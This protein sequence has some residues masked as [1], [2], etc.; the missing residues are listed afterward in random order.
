MRRF[1]IG[2]FVFV[3]LAAV[4][5]A[6]YAQ[7]SIVG[8]VRDISGAVMPGVTV[9]A[10]S[11][12]LIEKTRSVVTSGTGQ[13]AIVDL[14]PGT[15]TVTFTLPGFNTVRRE[16]IELTGNFVASVSVDMRVGAVEET[17]TV[18]GEAPIVDVTNSRRQQTISGDVIA[19]IPSS[20][21]Y[22]GLTTLV[23]ALNIQG[24]DIGGASGPIF[25][26][27]QIH[28][29]RRNE[30][31]VLV[32][33][34]S[35]GFQGMGVSFYVPEVGTAQEV[36][37]SLSGGLGEAPTGGPQ[38]NIVP[39][40]GGNVF[41]GSLFVTGANGAMQGD[42]IT[43]EIRDAGLT[44]RNELKK[45]WEVNPA[46][47]GPIRRDRL[48]F[49]GTFRHQGNRQL[50]AGMFENRN[51]GDP[52]KWTYD[53]DPSRQAIDDGTWKNGSL[54]LTWQATPRNKFNVWW[55]EQTVCQ[56]CIAGGS[57]TGLVFAGGIQ[58]P[59]A[60]GRTEGFPA[61]MAQATW[62]SP[63]SNRLL[64]EASLGLGPDL[65]FGGLQKNSYDKTLI[66]VT[67]QGGS[68]PNLAYRAAFWS[69][70]RGLTRV[71][72]GSL[73]YVTG[74]HNAKFGG[75][76]HYNDSL[77]VNFY[78]DSQLSYT[79]LNGSPTQLTMFGNHDV[80]QLVT[81]GMASL[82]A[83]DQWTR[84][85]LTLQGGVR[86][87]HLSA[88]FPDQQIGPNLYIPTAIRFPARDS[89]V[90]VKD[91]MPRVGAAYD[92]FG[93]G[94]TAVKVF[95]GRYV[96]P[97]NSGEAYAGGQ[98]PINRVVTMTNRAWTDN[99]NFRPDCNLLNPALQDNRASGGDLCGPWS[100][101]NFGKEVFATT[102][103]PD[104]LTG[105]N[106]REYSWD[107]TTTVS[108]QLA[109]RVSVELSYARR[110]WGNFQVTDN[111]AVGPA[112]F[113]PFTIVAPQDQRLPNGGGYSLQF[114]DIKPAKF[115]QFDNFI[116]FSDNYGK[117]IYH[118][119]GIDVN[120]NAR[121]PF[122][123]TLQGGFSTGNMT[124]DDCEVGESVP[125]IYIPPGGGGTLPAVQSTAQWSRT[126]CH[127][128]SG[129]L[130]HV[131]GLATYTVPKVDV[132]ISGTFQSKP[133]VGANFPNV[134]SQSIPANSVTPNAVIAP[135]LGRPLAGGVPVTVLGLVKPGDKY[136]DRLNQVDLRFGK[137][138]RFGG[139]RTLVALDLFNAFNTNTTDVYQTVYG[140]T[141]LNPAS[142]MA[143]RLAKIS[144]QFD[145]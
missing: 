119:N 17:V 133:Y 73:S 20:R 79:F 143:A 131:K 105:W 56:H 7:A 19:A 21:Q 42:N 5:I 47:G 48:W 55:D 100:N 52:T 29:G 13:Y 101:Q 117:Q 99:G 14:R 60:H 1:L 115:G 107:L 59:E 93:N 89:G 35:M 67:D 129:Y 118:F 15:Y 140:P 78:N 80:R 2:N 86:F 77:G 4:P 85:R 104:L 72:Q 95:I 57:R 138:L 97:T 43:Q 54:R 116:T 66:R 26:V 90:G 27:F 96:T 11:P 68:I 37:F 61:R 23:P 114:Y 130:T 128:E 36:T 50:V 113:D 103:D 137:L 81:Q 121:F 41:S 120:V 109:P 127:R 25:S 32:D 122:A 16:G 110:V 70:P 76:Y 136:G 75:R 145:F 112:D 31:Q 63:A 82:Y 132:L 39:R 9:E 125:E 135:S 92:L 91:I 46:L 44:G 111:R 65:Q 62:S 34:L 24:N 45:L 88:E 83:Q 28:G 134:A 69:R 22:F 3:S 144:A 12:A 139:T 33:G 142:I 71:A 84:G 123:L 53:P 98:N 74:S 141:Y 10:S 58:S 51:A 18:S 126:Y 87:E 102:Y 64:L 108:Q 49:Y 40:A 94:R 6:A 38:M 124:E 106:K 8:S 30:G